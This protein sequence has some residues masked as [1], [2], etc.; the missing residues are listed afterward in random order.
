M[1]YFS[2]MSLTQG[3]STEH[4]AAALTLATHS[5][6][7]LSNPICPW[8]PL[9]E[10]ASCDP[11]FHLWQLPTSIPRSYLHHH[12]HPSHCTYISPSLLALAQSSHWSCVLAEGW[13]G[14]TKALDTVSPHGRTEEAL[15]SFCLNIL[16]DKELTCR[17]LPTILGQLQRQLRDSESWSED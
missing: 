3:L 11:W 2:G 9:N 4:E 8:S 7:G 17:S 15:P 10:K 5:L 16:S 13:L 14:S 12:G 6:N 1:A